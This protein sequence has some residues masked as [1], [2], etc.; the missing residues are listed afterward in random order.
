[1]SRKLKWSLFAAGW[2]GVIT[3]GLLASRRTQDKVLTVSFVGFT[4]VSY[5]DRPLASF[6]S[7]SIEDARTVEDRLGTA[8]C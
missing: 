8:V 2:A 1:M 7:L 3:V 6:H 4:N 5:A